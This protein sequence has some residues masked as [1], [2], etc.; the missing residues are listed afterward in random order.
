MNNLK[1][2]TEVDLNYWKQFFHTDCE[3]THNYYQ[4]DDDAQ[5]LI[6]TSIPASYDEKIRPVVLIP[7]W[8]SQPSGW[9][10]VTKTVS[11][12]TKLIYIE[13][14]EKNSSK[15]IKHKNTKMGIERM[16][17]DI[18][19]MINN[20]NI[21]IQKS[22]FIASSLGGSALLHFL[23]TTETKP[24]QTVLMSPNPDFKLPPVVGRLIL[25][26]PLFM[27]RWVKGYVK[28]HVLKFRIDAKKNPEQA[29]K[30]IATFDAADPWKARM[31]AR[32]VTKF[33]AWDLLPKIDA[34]VILAGATTDQLH[35]SE[36]TI[37]VGKLIKNSQ[38][39]DFGSN[40][41]LHSEDFGLFLVKLAEDLEIEEL[42]TIANM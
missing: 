42:Q 29:L 5:L 15:V 36:R 22:I 14:R 35:K 27:I 37:N 9:I 31:S 13:T 32:H 18:L 20:L 10:G 17:Q 24:Y 34:N 39:I 16:S 26:M 7:G 28:W 25:S 11:S 41:A 19:E 3:I 40:L 8:F 6:I 33:K 30:Y 23:T 2:E 4:M 38:Y 21:D 12:K 1:N